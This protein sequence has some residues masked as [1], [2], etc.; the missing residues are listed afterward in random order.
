MS[1]REVGPVAKE[2]IAAKKRIEDPENWC[3]GCLLSPKGEMCALGAAGVR[4]Y[5]WKD[6]P[7][8]P[9]LAKSARE[10]FPQ[11]SRARAVCEDVD[12]AWWVNDTLGHSAVMRMYDHAINRALSEG[13]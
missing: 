3:V 4:G 5:E 9:L 8:V 11:A 1:N 6:N 13:K 10:L 12:F 2:L 7:L